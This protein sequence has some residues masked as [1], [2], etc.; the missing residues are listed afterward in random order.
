MDG[1]KSA[2]LKI[3]FLLAR[4]FTLS[5]FS[6]FVDTLRLGSDERDKSGR[7]ACDWLVMSSDRR[8]ATS[9]SGVQVVPTALLRP[10]TEFTY[11]VVVGGRLTDAEA[12]DVDTIRYLR[13]AVENGVPVIGLCTGS[14]ILAD[15]GLLKGRTA[16]VS[17][18][19]HNEFRELFP[20]TPVTSHE[21]FV[22]DD[23]IITCA[24]GSSAADLAAFLLNR[25]VGEFAERNALE[26]LQIARRRDA[27]EM[28]TRNPLGQRAD[29]KRVEMALLI[30]EQHLEDLLEIEDIA[31]QTG[32]S[33]RQ[34]ERSFRTKLGVSPA[35]AYLRVRLDAAM[36]LVKTTTLP[37]AEIAVMSGF[38]NSSHFIRKF[39]EC[40]GNPPATVRKNLRLETVRA[41]N[42]GAAALRRTA[43]EIN[44]T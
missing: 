36:R 33:R 37:L 27:R 12:L 26:I 11:I 28:Q 30:M 42:I 21:L 22:E 1:S 18:L 2:K 19:H 38:E 9:S 35:S 7:V 5:A 25:H 20:D 8:F 23:N 24:G 15:A 40:F 14:F 10:A 4:N 44:R 29:D 17:W 6:L 16:C 13:G 41:E 34:L 31:S 43:A 3:G 39:R 32:L